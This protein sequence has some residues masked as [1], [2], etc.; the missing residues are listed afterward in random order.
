MYATKRR[1][2][3]LT[4]AGFVLNRRALLAADQVFTNRTED[5]LNLRRLLS[6]R[7]LTYVVPG[8]QPDQFSFDAAARQELRQ[9]WGVGES[10]V[11]LSA[12]MFRPGVKSEGI[13]MVIRCCGE[14]YGQGYPL[15]LVIA[16]E[17]KE[18]PRLRRLAQRWLPERTRFLGQL[19]REDMHRFYSAGDLFVFPG[20]RESLGMVYL[21]AQSCGLPVVAFADGGVPEVV[22]NQVSGYLVPPSDEAGFTAAIARMLENRGQREEMGAAAS[23]YVRERHNLRDNYRSVEDTLLEL[24]A[25]RQTKHT[26]KR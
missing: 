8:I 9:K 10:L 17:G 24:V 21:E 25:R 12:A 4:W 19:D 3:W 26:S 6:D 2:H 1:K 13:S 16:G 22:A 15:H 14:L 11:V 5:L 18:G 23:R 7:K 20:I